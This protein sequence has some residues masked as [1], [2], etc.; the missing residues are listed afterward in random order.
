MKTGDLSKII[1]QEIQKCIDP[2]YAGKV[3][4]E[5]PGSPLFGDFSSN[6]AMILAKHLKKSPS[7]I[8][9]EIA[10]KLN[11]SENIK[12][13]FIV[14]VPPP[15]GFINFFFNDRTFDKLIDEI[16]ERKNDFG[17][18]ELKNKK[19]LLE[20]LSANP[21]GPMHLGNGR[22]GFTGDCLA[23][24]LEWAGFD[25]WREYYVNDTGNQ[26]INLGKSIMAASGFYAEQEGEKLYKANYINDLVKE[27]NPK[28]DDDIKEIGGRGVAIILKD[29]QRVAQ[30]KM[31]IKY[32]QWYSEQSLYDT[33]KIDAI[34]QWL[35]KENLI[36]EKDGARWF[37]SSRFGD[38]KD[39]VAVK[40]DGNK[41]YM[42][43]DIAYHKDKFE[44]GY[45]HLITILGADHHGYMGRT[46]AIIEALGYKKEQLNILLSQMVRLIEDGK[47]VRMSKRG[48]TFVTLEELIDEIGHDVARFF[49]VMRALETHMDFDLNL[50]KEH[51]SKNPVYYVQYAHARICSILKRAEGLPV[52]KGES[53]EK[54]EMTVGEA[55]LLKR[56]LVKFPKLI[57]N[58]SENYAVHQL[59][60]YAIKIADCFHKFYETNRVISA[61]GGSQP[62]PPGADRVHASGGEEVVNGE[63]LKT[64]KA[65]Q[66]VLKNVLTVIGVSAPEKM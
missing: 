63:R 37:A 61:K 39:R 9:N 19:I 47:E 40:S 16:L 51:S 31:R 8:A 10:E 36:Y 38:E 45:D 12:E 66:I 11:K 1:I 60:L 57:K 17:K 50:A 15:A 22:G 2:A 28:K 59:P 64:I 20:F 25:V 18:G 21:T 35:E 33:K 14:N 32:D 4:L 13:Y 42:L 44:R 52:I 41:T 56:Q 5:D 58:I 23:N 48:G 7:A 55:D 49:F 27:L 54:S 46:Y 26:V 3:S 53:K 6:I 29:I 65:A 30:D 24:V 43:S 62:N 34:L